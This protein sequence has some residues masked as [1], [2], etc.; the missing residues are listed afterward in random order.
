MGVERQ[1]NIV[2]ANTLQTFWGILAAR[3]ARLPA[4]WCQHESEEWSTYYDSLPEDM[5]ASAY[6]CFTYAYRVLYVADA[7]RRAWRAL[8]TRGNFE[9]IRHGIPPERLKAETE[10][11]SRDLVRTALGVPD[12]HLVLSVVG[13]VCRRKGQ[14]D[15]VHAAARLPEAIRSKTTIFVAGHI[16]EADYGR[17]IAAAARHAPGLR[18]VMTGRMND[19]FIYY[20]VADIAVCTSRFESAP[21]VLVEAM[22]CGLP[23]ITTPVFGIPEMVRK[24]VNCLFYDA[25]DVDELAAAVEKLW[26]DSAMRARF[27]QNSPIVLASQPAF[28]QMVKQYASVIKQAANLQC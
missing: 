22:A 14:L 8:E 12:D 6:Q 26:N 15:I 9:L 1:K 13:T 21:R 20:A 5:R 11:W 18:V 27:A 7:T 4:I 28:P 16:G 23:I 19:P 24:D 17:E 3:H 2:L 10:R 25:G